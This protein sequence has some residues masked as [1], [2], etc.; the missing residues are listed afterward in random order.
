MK[1]LSDPI[2]EEYRDRHS[3]TCA[4]L[5]TRQGK[6]GPETYCKLDEEKRF[7]NDIQER[8]G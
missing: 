5:G 2:Q 6:Y 8:I 1:T 4:R 3:G 7:K